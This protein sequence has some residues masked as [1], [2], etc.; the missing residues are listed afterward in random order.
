MAERRE[1]SDDHKAA[2]AE[3]RKQGRAVRT[4]LEALDANKPKRGR[5]RTPESIDK[6]LVRIDA[7]LGEADPL[8]KLNL[9]QE[10]LDLTAERDALETQVDLSELVDGFV[11]AAAG[12]SERK[13]ISYAAWRELGV[14]ASVLKA[15]GIKR[16]S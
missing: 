10:R 4:Y 9:I 6:R 8:K 14:D 11:E 13:G 5:K 3:G 2:L 1:M 12:Y 15:A 16:G 7:E